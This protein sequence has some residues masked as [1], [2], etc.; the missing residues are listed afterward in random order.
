MK[1]KHTQKKSANRG[2]AKEIFSKALIGITGKHGRRIMPLNN[3]QFT[4]SK[5]RNRQREDKHLKNVK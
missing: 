4:K 1:L 3:T 2:M 5:G